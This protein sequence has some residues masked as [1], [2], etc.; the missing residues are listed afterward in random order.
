MLASFVTTFF[1]SSFEE[2]AY[3]GYWGIITPYDVAHDLITA[4]YR[5]IKDGDTYG[6]LDDRVYSANK[7]RDLLANGPVQ[8]PVPS[9]RTGLVWRL[10]RR[11]LLGLP[12]VGAG[13]V[14]H[15]LLSAPFLGPVHWIAR[16]RGARRRNNSRDIAALIVVGLLIVGIGRALYK[17]YQ[18]T[19]RLTK[20]VLLRAEDVILEVNN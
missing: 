1:T 9:P 15:M 7:A 3:W 17:V 4:A 8:V 2:P 12:V 18:L 14:V 10:I 6:L 19:Q 5:V 13:S 16:Y 11:F 20:R